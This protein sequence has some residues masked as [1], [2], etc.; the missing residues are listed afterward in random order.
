VRDPHRGGSGIRYLALDRREFLGACASVALWPLLGGASRASAADALPHALLESSPFVYISPLRADGSESKCH[1]EVW[2]GWIGGAV[3]I[4]TAPTTWKS[5]A[6]AK[7][8]DRARIWVGDHGRVKQMIG[9]SD[10]FRSAPHF[11]ARVESVVK[12]ENLI[13]RLLALYAVKYPREI[14]R[15]RDEMRDGYKSGDR[16]LLRYTPV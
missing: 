11:D 9:Q 13:E 2:F 4:N 6:V 12:D 5:R 3:V 16:L 14:D 7:G 8:R 15:W 1:G 10:A